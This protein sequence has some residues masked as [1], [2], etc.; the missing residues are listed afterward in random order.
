MK[1]LI[2]QLLSTAMMLGMCLTAFAQHSYLT[3]DG[4]AVFIPKDFDAAQHLPSSI[5]LCELVPTGTVPASWQLRPQFSTKKDSCVATILVGDDVVFY[6]TD[7]SS[8]SAHQCL[9]CNESI[10]TKR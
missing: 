9:P 5:F 7:G 10:I 6:G 3:V 8:P 2:L 4:V 1:K